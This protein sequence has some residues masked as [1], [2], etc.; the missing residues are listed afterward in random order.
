MKGGKCKK[1]YRD[2]HYYKGTDK[3][4][5]EAIR[6]DSYKCKFYADD[7]TCYQEMDL[8]MNIREQ[9]FIYAVLIIL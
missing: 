9:N 3:A 7:N 4:K 2:C 5:C 8:A 6:I 1:K